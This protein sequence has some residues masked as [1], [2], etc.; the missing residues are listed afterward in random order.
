[1]TT[2]STRKE[3]P[4]ESIELAKQIAGR[5]KERDKSKLSRAAC[6]YDGQFYHI[7]YGFSEAVKSGNCGRYL[8]EIK[9]EAECFTLTGVMYLIARE[10]GLNPR[11]MRMFGMQ[12]LKDG[13]R[14]EDAMVSDHSFIVCDIGK[15]K[16]VI[17]PFMTVFGRA[18]FL[19]D[20]HRVE[21]YTEH[22]KKMTTRS[23]ANLQ[24]LS[25]EEYLSQLEENRS[26]EGGRKALTE[27]QKV[28]SNKSLLFLTYFP[29]TSEIRS[30]IRFGSDSLFTEP[31]NK[32]SAMDLITRVEE[33]GDYDFGEG[34]LEFYDVA[35]FNWAHPVDRQVAL[36]C[37]VPLARN[38]WEIIDKIVKSTGRKSVATKMNGIKLRSQMFSFGF[39]DGFDVLPDSLASKVI[40]SG[41]L[42]DQYD[43]FREGRDE[44]L[45]DYLERCSKDEFSFKLFL[46]HAHMVKGRDSARTEENPWGFIFS[47]DDHEGLLN[48]GFETY[49]ANLSHV[50]DEYMEDAR[51]KAG[52]LKKS[53][54]HYER[55]LQ[56]ESERIYRSNLPFETMIVLRGNSHPQAFSNQADSALFKRQFD[57]DRPIDDLEEGLTR[58]D[59]VRGAESRL[60]VDL[61]NAYQFNNAL[62][63]KS[64]KHGL[65]K[66]LDRRK[67]Q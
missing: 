34:R 58:E 31:R 35:K 52:I 56:A 59:L 12:D 39:Q 10:A 26:P 49:K 33:D 9:K 22:A 42:G 16:Q 40:D 41:D 37:P 17:D 28:Q 18:R 63:L 7:R 61:L 53:K 29:E 45:E 57:L 24:E 21:I 19:D 46:R 25:P 23:Y 66:I 65:K 13:E 62:F 55:R 48:E 20:Q 8:H 3:F 67:S 11:I 15:T 5:Y 60:F 2:V 64:F 14:A 30:S 4:K 32:K 47:S 36:T 1:M 43:R 54:F 38:M 27:T 6:L 50:F 44:V 51:V